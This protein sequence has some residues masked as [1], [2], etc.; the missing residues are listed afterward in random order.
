MPW[1]VAAAVVGA[2]ASVYSASQSGEAPTFSDGKANKFTRA[3]DSYEESV[4]PWRQGGL[5]AQKQYMAQMGMGGDAFDITKLP[6][7]AGA[8]KAGMRGVNQGAAGSGMLMSGNRLTALRDENQG[9]YGNYFQDY[10]TRLQGLSNQGLNINTNIGNMRTGNAAETERMN[11]DQSIN[12]ANANNARDADLMSAFGTVAGKGY[13]YFKSQKT[14]STPS[15]TP[16]GGIPF[17]M[18]NSSWGSTYKSS[19]DPSIFQ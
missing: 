16:D 13:D 18:G 4:S 14:P 15:T 6:G 5:D 3:A 8:E 7:Y 2:G 19:Y 9:L 17:S 12:E 11:Y 1:G 10:M